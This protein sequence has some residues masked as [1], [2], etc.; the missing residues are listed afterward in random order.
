MGQKTLIFRTSIIYTI[1]VIVELV[2]P[3]MGPIV[4]MTFG[5]VVSEWQMVRVSFRNELIGI[6]ICFLVGALCGFIVFLFLDAG[7][8]NVMKSERNATREKILKNNISF[9]FFTIRG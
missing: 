4:G 2:S 3:L 7:N 5:T 1:F 9:F 6:G 8:D